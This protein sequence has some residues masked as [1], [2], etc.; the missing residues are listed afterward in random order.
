MTNCD[1]WS[2]LTPEDFSTIRTVII[3]CKTHDEVLAS[4]DPTVE[5]IYLAQ[6]KEAIDK[7]VWTDENKDTHDEDGQPSE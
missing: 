5:E 4:L 7:H 6:A 3:F 2:Y 1:I